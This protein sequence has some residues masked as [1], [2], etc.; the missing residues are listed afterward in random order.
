MADMSIVARPYARAAFEQAQS[1][2]GGL[3][4]WSDMLQLAALVTSDKSMQAA[5]ASPSLDDTAKAELLVEVCGE[6]AAGSI[7]K[8]G[9]NFITLLAE[10]GRLFAISDIATLFE[11]L[12]ADAERTIHAHVISAF[13]IDADQRAKIA[14]GLKKRLNREVELEVAVDES[15]IG[16]AIIRAGDLV[17]D[18]SVRGHL[19]KLAT[20]L[21]Q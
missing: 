17:I 13:E 3:K 14:K 16:G 18:G 20:V 5:L 1:T 4:Q 7:T 8:E 12:R 11:R 19:A 2:K 10:R 15:L 21:R 6:I 9:R